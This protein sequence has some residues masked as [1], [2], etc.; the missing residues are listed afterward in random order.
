MTEFKRKGKEYLDMERFVTRAE[1][2]SRLRELWRFEPGKESVPLEEAN[3]RVCAEEAASLLTLPVARASGP[4]GIAVRFADFADK[5]PDT[6]GWKEGVD[7]VAADCGDDFDD[8]FDTVINIERVSFSPEGGISINLEGPLKQGQMVRPRG[9][10]L[11]EGERVIEAGAKICPY[12][13]GLL[14]GA[15]L[16]RITVLAKPKVA[17]IP[18]GNELVP[19]GTVPGRGQNV[20][21]NSLMAA[22]FLAEWQADMKALPVV[23]DQK[24][25]LEKALDAA[26]AESDIVILNGGSSMGSEDFVSGLLSRRGSFSQH[27][28][29]CIPGMPMAVAIVDGKPVINMPGPPFAAYCAFDWCISPLIAHWYGQPA[30]KRKRVKAMLEKEITKPEKM[31]F[32]AR[33]H[34]FEN[35]DGVLRADP[36]RMDDRYAQATCRF[37]GLHV[38]PIGRATY[39]AGQEIEAEI[40]HSAS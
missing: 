31:E 13:L 27:G 3:R 24:A 23:G 38:M 20:E 1:A 37:N 10:T 39:E 17:F 6:S 16:D 25:K 2:L 19:R 15:G 8:A 14:A 32:Y 33:L 7:Y 11:R 12:H 34:L 4:D 26:L 28:V 29:R 18:T 30:P 22:T 21:S 36:I 35:G 9:A 40:L 5:N